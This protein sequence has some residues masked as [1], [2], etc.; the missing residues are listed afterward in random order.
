MMD[1][2]SLIDASLVWAGV[3]AIL[4]L[5]VW[6]LSSES[7]TV[8]TALKPDSVLDSQGESAIKKAA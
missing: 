5:G 7:T 2:S 4:F 3:A 1:I 8:S 6:A